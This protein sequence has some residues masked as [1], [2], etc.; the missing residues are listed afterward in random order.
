M[1]MRRIISAI[2]LLSTVAMANA[3]IGVGDKA[4]AI[5]VDK[6]VKGSSVN[7]DK[8]LHVVEFWATWCGPCKQ[9]IPHL[10]ELA[11]EFKGKADF[12]GVS[13][14]ENG[15]D[16][17]GQVT[18]FVKGMGPAMDYNVAIDTPSKFMATNWME[19]AKQ[20]GIP[21]AF[22]IKDGVILWIGHPMGGLSETLTK[23]TSGK[24]D[25]SEAKKEF[26]AQSMK[27]AEQTKIQEEQSKA[28]K[29][30][31][32][33]VKAGDLD[34][35]IAGL[36]GFVAK[37]PAMKLQIDMLKAT[38]L[39][40]KGDKSAYTFSDGLVSSGPMKDNPQALNQFAWTVVQP[41]P[42]AKNPDFTY[43]VKW[44]QKA[45]E[46]TKRSDPAILDTYAL[47]LFKTGN[48]AKAV[49]IETAA[50]ALIK[51]SGDPESIKSYQASLDGFV[52]G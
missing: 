25:V 43:A 51:K 38:V 12:T 4:P 10:T 22:V 50:L 45:V 37:Y 13:V 23:V 32:D 18:K 41:K 52:K 5:K 49:E 33:A 36:D 24:F 2:G 28:I 11:R 48:K 47:A 21:T 17:L 7:L 34:G 35:Q 14:W 20:D 40:T 6:I 8:G 19:A 3:S 15:A 42:M 26:E 1:G 27:A 44:A 30:Y 16:Q 46:L 31:L 9:S 39:I 29:P